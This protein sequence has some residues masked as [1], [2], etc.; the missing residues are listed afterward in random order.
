M[1]FWSKES[2]QAT[3]NKCSS[4]DCKKGFD[5]I[6]DSNGKIYA[7]HCIFKYATCRDPSIKQ[8]KKGQCGNSGT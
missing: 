4:D 5:P 3:V 8:V 2:S 1:I 6:C 7:N